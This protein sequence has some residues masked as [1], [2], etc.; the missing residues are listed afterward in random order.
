MKQIYESFSEIASDFCDGDS[1]THSLSDHTSDDCLAWQ[2]G[3]YE[4][5]KFL[6]G[7][8]IKLVQ[9]PAVYFKLWNK[10]RT[11]KPIKTSHHPDKEVK[12]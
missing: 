5:A 1:W 8:G 10:I 2:H 3:V 4:F 7:A 9:S 6:D 12:Q 11:H